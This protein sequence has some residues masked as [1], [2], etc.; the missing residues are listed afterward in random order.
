MNIFES[1]ENL[2]VSEECFNDILSIVEEIINEVSRGE[3][4]KRIQKALEE[5]DKKAEKVDNK[6]GEEKEEAKTE[7]VKYS[8]EQL[9][10][11]DRI[12]NKVIDRIEKGKM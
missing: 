9:P 4:G 10:K 12:T 11:I 6:E 8:H 5:I 7:L 1:L 3:V 2:Q